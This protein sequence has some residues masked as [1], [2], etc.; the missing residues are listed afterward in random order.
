MEERASKGVARPPV[1]LGFAALGR[2]LEALGR[3]R[4]GEQE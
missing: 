2:G 4:V 3:C 1:R